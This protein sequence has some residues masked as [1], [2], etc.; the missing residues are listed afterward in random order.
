LHEEGITGKGISAAI[1]DKPINPRHKEIQDHIIYIP[2][3]SDRTKDDQRDRI[4]FHGIA[5]A[6]I[7]CGKTTGVAPDTKLYYFAVADDANY[8]YSYCL[9]LEK[10]L[11]VNDTLPE[12][13]NA[14]IF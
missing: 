2:V 14:S 9:A 4:H 6:S 1:F 11:A 8:T 7:L 13:Q 10:L 3:H 12:N 5:C